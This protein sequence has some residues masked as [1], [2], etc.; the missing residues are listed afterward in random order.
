MQLQPPPWTSLWPRSSHHESTTP[1]SCSS[2]AQQPLW[3]PPMPPP[4]MGLHYHPQLQS[5]PL[6]CRHAS[7]KETIKLPLPYLHKVIISLLPLPNLQN[8]TRQATICHFRHLP[9]IFHHLYTSHEP[10]QRC[11]RRKELRHRHRLHARHPKLP[12]ISLQNATANHVKA[13]INRHSANA[14]KPLSSPYRRRLSPLLTLPP[15]LALPPP[16]AT[17]HC[18]EGGLPWLPPHPLHLVYVFTFEP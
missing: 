6:C 8:Y 3:E 18:V 10:H 13:T 1:R 14:L 17:P 2:L 7:A 15:S 4:Y 5:L 11:Q 16:W 12:S 9:W